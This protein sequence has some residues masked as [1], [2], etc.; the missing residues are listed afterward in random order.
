VL[1]DDTQSQAVGWDI[2]QVET[3]AV[4]AHLQFYTGL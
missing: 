3:T 4:V 2:A 1:A